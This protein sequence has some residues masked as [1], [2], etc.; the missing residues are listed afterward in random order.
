MTANPYELQDNPRIAI[1]GCGKM[2]EAA[3]AG[4]ISCGDD[5]AKAF[6]S[7]DFVAVAP[8]PQTRERISRTHGV[9]TLPSV[10]GLRDMDGGIDI[11]VLAV[12]PQV[13][14]DVLEQL[15]TLGITEGKLVITMAAGLPI[16]V[17]E[18]ALPAARVIRVMPNMPLQVGMGASAIACGRLASQEDA[19]L[20]C[21]LFASLGMAQIVDE[22]QIDAVC[23]IS[24]AGPA[25]V[26]YMV[27]ALRDAGVSA[28]LDGDFAERLALQSV[29]G[30]FKAMS[31]C[32]TSPEEM[33]KS[34]CSPGGTTL[35]ALAAMDRAGFKEMYASAVDAAILRANELA[36]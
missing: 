15:S 6:S 5:V 20:A 35:A 28:G 21:A 9:D 18:K 33:R 36:G 7:G 4:W 13:M 14:P 31:D 2:G 19:E 29:G 27:E 8:S 22:S 17:Y 23:A 32:G 25:Y 24:G 11:F 16:E 3:M 34:V 1:V 30:T 12:K 26:A 10:E